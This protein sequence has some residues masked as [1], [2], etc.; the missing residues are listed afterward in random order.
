MRVLVANK[1]WY[2]R[3]G[4]ERVMF[5]EL[6]A[7]ERAGVEVAHFSTSHPENAPSPWSPYF[8][9]YLELGRGT[10]LGV[11]DSAVAAARMFWNLS[12]ARSF[13]RLVDE[14]EPDLV[15]IH[16]IHRQLS[17]SILFVARRKGIPVVQTLHDYHHICPADVLLRGGHSPCSPTACRRYNTLACVAEKCVR[18]SLAAS[19]LSATETAWQRMCRS[20]ER[21]VARFISPSEF[22]AE[23]M[24]E[25]GWDSV[26][27]DVVPNGVEIEVSP[28]RSDEGFFLIVSRLSPEKGVDVA[29][30]AA[31]RASVRIVVAGG[32]PSTSSLRDEFPSVEF[33]GHVGPEEVRDLLSRCTALV[34]PSLWFENAPMSI[35]EAMS[36]ATPIIA[37]SIGGIPEQVRHGVDGMLVPPNEENALADAMTRMQSDASLSATMG[38]SG[39][40]RVA[41]CFSLDAHTH[42]LL[43]VYGRALSDNAS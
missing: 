42:R 32:G 5:D 34:V 23:R 14:F 10:Q 11:R 43:E 7:L 9:P 12:A 17:P 8:A 28:T 30:R 29:L 31:A 27:I 26:P 18:G 19:T 6:E 37:S 40:R 3:G 13:G 39:C 2:R 24:R 41:E 25:G 16:G 4:L 22:L 35:L 36:Q 38:Q 1:F 15:H 20:Y 33:R 21:T